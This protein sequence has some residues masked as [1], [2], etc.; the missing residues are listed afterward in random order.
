MTYKT[1]KT[2][3]VKSGTC[4][5]GFFPTYETPTFA[6][7]TPARADS[8]AIFA[9]ETS[10]LFFCRFCRSALAKASRTVWEFRR[11]GSSLRIG[12]N[13]GFPRFC[14]FCRRF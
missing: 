1:Y 2:P 12:S 6:Y 8:Q 4:F 3:P 10:W 9:Y 13:K 5:A 14:R 7:K 11:L